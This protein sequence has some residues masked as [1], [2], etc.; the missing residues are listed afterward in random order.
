MNYYNEIKNELIDN[1]I[2]KRVKDYSK[3]NYELKK[4]YNVGK[5]L[6]DAGKHY[7]QGIIK[8][9]SKRL[10]KDL[11]QK[12]DV[13]SLNKMRKYY[14]LVQKMATMSPFLTYSHYIEI[15]PI[16]NLDKI[17]YYIKVCEQQKLSVRKLREKIKSKEYE[18]LSNDALE[19][20]NNNIEPNMIELIPDPILIPSNGINKNELKENVLKKIILENLDNF[21]KQFGEGYCYIG[22][23]YP[24]KLDRFYYIDILLFNIKYNCYIVIELKVNELKKED[25]GQICFYINYINKHIKT[26]SQNKTI[27]IILVK[28]DNKLVLEYSTDERIYS[29]TYELI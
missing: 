21:L 13:S 11:N 4:Y 26:I 10:T 25:I 29:R 23:E 1:E 12:Y 20:I 19:K 5:L 16:N 6:F 2:N 24:I 15:L 7:G 27:G 18:R 22:N 17:K 8:E 9:Y 28:K 3:N 14:L